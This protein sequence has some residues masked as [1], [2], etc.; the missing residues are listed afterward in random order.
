M[1]VTTSCNNHMRVKKHGK[2]SGKILGKV[3]TVT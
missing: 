2:K 1:T 3:Q